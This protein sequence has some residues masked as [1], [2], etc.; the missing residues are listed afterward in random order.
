MDLLWHQAEVVNTAA[1]LRFMA[2][3]A[4]CDSS[5][6]IIAVFIFLFLRF[7]NSAARQTQWL[8]L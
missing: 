5:G 2:E 3:T 8:P 1:E 6:T 4:L 7:V